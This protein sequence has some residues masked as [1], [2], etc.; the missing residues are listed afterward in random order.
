[1]L[2]L[3]FQFVLRLLLLPEFEVSDGSWGG[4][5]ER[6]GIFLLG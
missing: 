1:M 6:G 3:Q 2:S 5:L 4:I